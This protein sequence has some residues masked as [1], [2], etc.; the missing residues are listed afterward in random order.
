M[1]AQVPESLV[2][3]GR[4]MAMHTKPLGDYFELAGVKPRFSV[5]TSGLWRGYVGS[6][7]ILDDR[8]Y[9]VGI[10]AT[11]E[12]GTEATLTT[13]FPGFADRVFAHWYCGTLRIDDGK[14]LRSK[15]TSIM[16]I[17]EREIFLEV[18]RGVVVRKRVQ[19]NG[20]D[21]SSSMPE[22]S[23]VAASNRSLRGSLGDSE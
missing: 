21:D 5:M 9:L 16:R 15:S 17:Y 12:D 7:E 20:T 8:L 1:T 18:E 14:W 19:H 3:E 22:G 10:S 6:W 11:F 4:K 13:F 23:S 2:Y